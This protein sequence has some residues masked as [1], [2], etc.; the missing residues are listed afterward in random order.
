MNIGEEIRQEVRAN[1]DLAV[2]W[3]HSTAMMDG[4]ELSEDDVSK[5]HALRMYVTGFWKKSDLQ[6]L[7]VKIVPFVQQKSFGL[8]LIKVRYGIEVEAKE[9]EFET[10]FN[11]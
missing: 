4:L 5:M 6:N 10:V 2:R 9:D 1:E 7:V 8:T 11:L 3:K